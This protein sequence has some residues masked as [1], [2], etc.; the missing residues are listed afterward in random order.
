[1]YLKQQHPELLFFPS[2]HLSA[3]IFCPYLNP[4]GTAASHPDDEAGLFAF[5]YSI[6]QDSLGDHRVV[7][8]TVHIDSVNPRFI[9]TGIISLSLAKVQYLEMLTFINL[10]N[11]TGPFQPFISP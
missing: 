8:H 4:T 2:R 10:K 9:L 6:T 5:Q 3:T 11:M 7:E 1:L